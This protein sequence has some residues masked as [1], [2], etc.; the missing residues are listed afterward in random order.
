[1]FQ[2]Y[3]TSH[4]GKFF[5][6]KDEF[7]FIGCNMYELANVESDISQKMLA[8]A[9][10]QRFDVVRF[11]VFNK[12]GRNNL[13]NICEISTELNL[14]LIPVLA[15]NWGYLMNE[16]INDEWYLSGYKNNYLQNILD[17]SFEFSDRKEIL[18]WELINEPASVNFE[19]VFNFTKDVSAEFKKINSN[20]LLSVGTIGGIGDKFGNEFSRFNSSNFEKLYT[21]KNLDAVSIHDYSF[22]S[23]IAERLDIHQRFK[24]KYSSSAILNNLDRIINFIPGLID[25]FTLRKFNDVY[26]IPLTLRSI[27]QKYISK[28]IQTSA[29]LKKPLY[30][31]EIGFKKEMGSDRKKVIEKEL[32]K[33]LKAGVSGILLWSFESEGRSKDG[34]DYGFD[35]NDGFKEIIKKIKNEYL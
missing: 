32:V 22:N 9:K 2:N 14:R 34:H 12:T 10:D 17:L 33:Y 23:T 3:I 27:W 13:N 5:D 26:D 29:K 4:D 24:G 30:I 31:G 7:R 21:L 28:N 19:S 11:W 20:H 35:E 1:M 6:G 25:K 18:L 15:D 8:S 16:E